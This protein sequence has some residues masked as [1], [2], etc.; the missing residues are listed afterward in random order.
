MR[1]V[2]EVTAAALWLWAQVL[3]ASA[4]PRWEQLRLDQAVWSI[5][6]SVVGARLKIAMDSGSELT[7]IKPDRL[8]ALGLPAH[9]PRF[10]DLRAAELPLLSPAGCGFAGPVV[11]ADTWGAG[12]TFLDASGPDGSLGYDLLKACAVAVDFDAG[13]YR[14][15]VDPT[16]EDA[17]RLLF[18]PGS[19]ARLVHIHIDQQ[20]GGAAPS[21]EVSLGAATRSAVLDM[22]SRISFLNAP[23]AGSADWPVL[24]EIGLQYYGGTRRAT[25]VQAP[26][27]RVG[28]YEVR[29]ALVGICRRSL[30]TDVLSWTV[31]APAGKVLFDFK[32]QEIV[33]EKRSTTGVECFLAEMGLAV[34]ES[35]VLVRPGTLAVAAGLGSEDHVLAIGGLSVAG[36]AVADVV[37]GLLRRQLQF[38]ML[39]PMGVSVVAS[40]AGGNRTVFVP[41]YHLGAA[42]NGRGKEEVGG[43]PSEVLGFDA[44]KPGERAESALYLVPTAG[45]A[46][47]P[48]GMDV[49]LSVNGYT[50][51]ESTGSGVLKPGAVRLDHSTGETRV[52]EPG[53]SVRFSVDRPGQWGVFVP[54][55]T[56]VPRLEPDGNGG[57]G[58]V[59][60]VGQAV[61]R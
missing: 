58:F 28:P 12:G 17:L 50:F 40:R 56:A 8:T 9:I 59:L 10:P 20:S 55:G 45:I 32:N 57:G 39:S 44:V 38:L 26:D 60:Q 52:V 53:E 27:L 23:V 13:K 7:W 5:E 41:A 24:Q 48:D 3:V 51:V 15:A 33:L 49:R 46:V 29:G 11:C 31:F 6:A 25:L 2:L 61:K 19:T 54:K 34:T 43:E 4:Q 14:L 35:G 18:P 21:L 37:S 22:G 30:G 1:G 36:G 47:V 42:A 16:P